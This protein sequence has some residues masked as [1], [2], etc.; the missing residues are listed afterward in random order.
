MNER[1]HLAAKIYTLHDQARR[2]TRSVPTW[3]HR[4]V[5]QLQQRSL[6]GIAAEL[7]R[8]YD[9]GDRDIAQSEFDEIEASHM[10]VANAW[11]QA[12]YQR[13]QVEDLQ[14]KIDAMNGRG[15]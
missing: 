3:R 1:I 2:L 11:H 5:D 7:E 6:R 15:G 12:A 4:E 14:D 9:R 13:W 8:L 10:A